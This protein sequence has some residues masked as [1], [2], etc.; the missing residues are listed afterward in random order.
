M[1]DF[2]VGGAPRSATTW[3]AA[4]LRRHPGVYMPSPTPPEPKF[5]LVDEE[6]RKGL[7]YYSE[8]WFA[9]APSDSILGEKSANYLESP[10]AA[11]RLARDLPRARLVFCLR[12]PALRA[13]SNYRWSVANGLETLGF[14]EALEREAEREAAYSGAQRYSRPFSYY[15]RGLYK[16]EL[17]PYFSC[18]RREQLLVLRFESILADPVA[19]AR[20]LHHFLGVVPRPEDA[21]SL[22]VLNAAPAPVTGEVPEVVRRVR[23]RYRAA[24]CELADTLGAEF[25]W[26]E[27]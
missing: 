6:Y 7:R 12:D 27:T 24:N 16:Q 2:I 20:R 26:S 14:G 22:G 10:E 3:L 4:L 11:R 13:W 8:R 18:F 1:P 17:E 5:F 25:A 19:V 23:R 15:S 21:R 9:A